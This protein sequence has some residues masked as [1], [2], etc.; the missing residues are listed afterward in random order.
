MASVLSG[1]PKELTHWSP[2]CVGIWGP[3]WDWKKNMQHLAWDFINGGSFS[4]AWKCNHYNNR[5]HLRHYTPQGAVYRT[6]HHKYLVQSSRLELWGLQCVNTAAIYCSI[7]QN[8]D[9]LAIHWTAFVCWFGALLASSLWSALDCG[10]SDC[11]A[12]SV[13]CGSVCC[14]EALR[15]GTALDCG[16]LNCGALWISGLWRGCNCS[17][18]PGHDLPLGP[19]VIHGGHAIIITPSS[20]SASAS[21]SASQSLSN[22]GPTQK[23][24]LGGKGQQWDIWKSIDS[25]S[26]RYEGRIGGIQWK[27][28]ST[29][30]LVGELGPVEC[31][32]DTF[33]WNTMVDNFENL[34]CFT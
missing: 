22:R 5:E 20:S 2:D 26:G 30:S 18:S 24:Q 13:H 11:G 4:P 19:P 21:A 6:W 9:T 29:K 33:R 10:A 15:C 1:P 34:K 14:G 23:I 3:R 7:W 12:A 17:L 28:L 31:R 25:E 27:T 16:A 32:E 8:C